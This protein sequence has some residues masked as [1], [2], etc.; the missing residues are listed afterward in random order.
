MVDFLGMTFVGDYIISTG[1]DGYI[2]IW[3]DRKIIK[4]IKVRNSPLSC[5]NSYPN[6]NLFVTG[7]ANGYIDVF[8]MKSYDNIE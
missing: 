5:I 6:S 8:K 2:Y 1:H 7:S 4:A 3:K